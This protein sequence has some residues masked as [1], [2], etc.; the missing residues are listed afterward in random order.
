[1]VHHF[2]CTL[3]PSEMLSLHWNRWKMSSTMWSVDRPTVYRMIHLLLDPGWA[4]FYLY[5]LYV[6]SCLTT[7]PKFP[8]APASSRKWSSQNQIQPNPSLWAVEST[9]S[10][11]KIDELHTECRWRREKDG[12]REAKVERERWDSGDGRGEWN[13]K[14]KSWRVPFCRLVVLLGDIFSAEASG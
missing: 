7:S 1:M 9:C 3:Y 8:S 13:T 5:V 11:S 12:E 6:V 14:S 4:D 10:V 2:V